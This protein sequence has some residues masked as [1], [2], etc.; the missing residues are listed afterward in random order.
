MDCS[1]IPRL[2]ICLP[3]RLLAVTGRK[4]AKKPSRWR[5]LGWCASTTTSIQAALASSSPPAPDQLLDAAG[6]LCAV[7]LIAGRSGYTLHGQPDNEDE[8]PTLDPCGGGHPDRLR[9]ALATKLFKGESDNRFTPVHRH[10]AEFLSARYLAQIIHG[11]LPARRV[12]ALMTGMDGIV[13]TEMRGLSAWL[14]AHCQ[15]TRADLIE[16][17]PIGVGLYGD[18]QTF[19]SAEKYRLL[20]SLKREGSRIEP[21]LDP[22]NDHSMSSMERRAAIFSALATPDMESAFKEVLAT[23]DDS[24]DHQ[25]FTDFVLRILVQSAPLPRL[26]DKL[27]EI[28]YDNTRFPRVRE[29]ALKAFIH[30]CPDSQDKVKKLKA[31]L[32]GIQTGHIP[33]SGYR[34]PGILL[35]TLYPDEVT[36]SEVWSYFS[37]AENLETVGRLWWLWDI[38]DK[39]SDDQAAELLDDLQQRFSELEPT[40]EPHHI[41]Q[42]SLP[43]TLL[44]RGLKADGAQ[45]DTARLYDW[46]GVGEVEDGYRSN[47]KAAQEIRSWLEQRPKIQKDL[48]MEGLNRCPVSGGF[49]LYCVYERLY[50]ASLPPDFGLWCLNQ[51]AAKATWTWSRC[52]D[53]PARIRGA[54]AEKDLSLRNCEN[55]R[56]EERVAGLGAFA[57]SGTARQ[58]RKGLS[59]HLLYQL[60]EGCRTKR[61]FEPPHLLQW[62]RLRRGQRP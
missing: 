62:Y 17:D 14:A 8:Y 25:L 15:E 31:L 50:H 34:I 12:I 49:N 23:D 16:R 59:A 48:F 5:V 46:L 9:L 36:P 7:Q 43:L 32:A 35:T 40:L 3:R 61:Y 53:G 1:S 51:A 30:N 54:R 2:S 52:V 10:V 6:R 13:V 18:I 19:S 55:T 41:T 58:S 24:Q 22:Q 26:T 29:A 42:A 57:R 44:A 27:L 11:G 33:D 20:N 4:A 45:L 56:Q 47:D 21:H 37:K 39:A 60:E 38:V 28:T